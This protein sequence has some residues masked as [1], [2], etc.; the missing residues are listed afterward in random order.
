MIADAPQPGLPVNLRKDLVRIVAPNPS[1]M[2]YWGTNTFLLGREKLA[3]IDPGPLS[4]QHLDAILATVG[5]KEVTHILVTHSHLDHSP[6]ARPLSEKTGAP[7]FAFGDSNAGQ[8]VLMQKLKANGLTGGGEGVDR[9]FAPDEEVV[10]GQMIEGD[11][12]QLR[13]LHTPGHMGNHLCFRWDD[14]LFCGDHVMGWASSL[15]SPPD[16]DLTDFMQSC[17]RLLT[18]DARVYFPAHGDEIT[19]PKK[20]LR[21][22]IEHRQSRERQ[23]LAALAEGTVSPQEIATKIYTTTPASLLP[24]AARNVFAHLLDLVQREEVRALGAITAGARFEKID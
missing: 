24:A 22:L 4:T 15:V 23:I 3:V 7:I 14:A 5:A 20:R 18:D 13:S 11:W 10:D 21:W 1:P 9:D 12:G 2:T 17:V 19:D 6:L 16:G 8:S